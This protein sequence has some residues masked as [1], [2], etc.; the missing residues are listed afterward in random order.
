MHTDDLTFE[1]GDGRHQGRPVPLAFAVPQTGV[2]I[3][4]ADDPAVAAM[5]EVTAARVV[6]VSR[7][8]TGS[9]Q[10][11]VWAGPVSLAARES[12]W[13]D[14]APPEREPRV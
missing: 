5:A 13:P 7:N 3:L 14:A 8:S 9:D 6:R 12:D 1:V 2:V 4:N 11:Q 10:A